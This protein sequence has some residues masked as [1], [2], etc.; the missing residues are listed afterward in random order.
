MKTIN[1]DDRRLLDILRSEDHGDE[2]HE[3]MQHVEQCSHCQRRLE[4]LAAEPEVWMKAGEAL[5]SRSADRESDLPAGVRAEFQLTT[6]PDG[7]SSWTE[8]IARR[9]L[10]P[11]SHPEMLGRLGRYEVERM[12]GAGGMGIVFKAFD[13]ELNRPVAIKVLSPILAGC[14]SARMRF[15]RE[16]RA[17]AAIVHEHV[18]PIHNVETD[19]DAPF[20]VMQYI[21][22]ESLQSRIDRAGPLQICEVLRIGFQ[23]AAGL[24]AAHQQGLVHRDIK[25][26]NILLEQGVDRALLS[27]F[28]LARTADDATLT[29][30]GFHPGTPQFMSPE[31][32]AGV[33][34]DSRSD[35]FSLGG[36]LYTMC[37]S[38]PPFRSE[39]SLGVMKRIADEE[40]NRIR[41]IN[42]TIPDWLC[43]IIAKLMAKRPAD[44][45]ESAAEV[46]HLLEQCLAHVQQPDYNPLPREARLLMAKAPYSTAQRLRRGGNWGRLLTISCVVIGG[47]G[48]IGALFVQNAGR[49]ERLAALQGEWQLVAS[50]REGQALPAEEL[51]DERLIIQE[52]RFSQFQTAPSGAEIRGESGRLSIVDWTSELAIDFN[53]WEGTAHGLAQ[54]SG[55]ELVLCVT[56]EGGPRPDALKTAAGDSRTLKTYQRK[57]SPTGSPVGAATVR[58]AKHQGK[59]AATGTPSRIGT[60][61]TRPLIAE[62]APVVACLGPARTMRLGEIVTQADVV[63]G[64]D[65]S[66]VRLHVWDCSKSD[67]SRV[68]LI[69]RSELGT[70]SPDGKIMLTSEGET[71]DLG[72]KQ[73]QQYSGFRVAAGQ[74]IAA[75]QLSRSKQFASAIIHLRTD[76]ES[77]Q[78][79]PPT[80]DIRHFWNLR[81]LQLDGASHTGK[82][83]GEFPVNAR[84]GVAF[85]N[86]ESLVVHSTDQHYIVCREL[87][88]GNIRTQFAPSL[89]V[90]GAVG[91]AIAPNGQTVAAAGYQGSLFLWD[92]PSGIL[93]VR[94]DGSGL[95]GEPHSVF[96]AEVLRFSPD[97]CY[98]ALLSG[99][100]IR[101]I[102]VQTGVTLH[103]HQDP[104][105]S[106]YV[107]AQWSN[108]AA[109]I[110]LFTSSQPVPDKHADRLPCVDEWQWMKG[111][112]LPSANPHAKPQTVKDAAS[113]EATPKTSRTEVTAEKP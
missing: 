34:V 103:E 6:W 76:V 15:A 35:L 96:R 40:P 106:R 16:A 101:V 100:R 46:A 77:L 45:F 24:A 57:G 54:L 111:A 67:L 36:V 10:A 25:P 95:S 5:S 66:V 29:R 30:S 33:S 64:L 88:S 44:R 65:P 1:C 23:V 59:L 7:T 104:R 39:S 62:S 22:G 94:L 82:K 14:G 90:H 4:E 11:P 13:S 72:S 19:R 38:R 26:G 51:F 110:S 20:L 93:R 49:A 113:A 99:N 89:G 61:I 105:R 43:A 18:V 8:A 109:T 83:L 68:L 47:V 84:P 32:V 42:P 55:D 3:Q 80:E 92:V 75:L 48:L 98:L 73:T 56:R 102:D 2:V 52:S 70:L 28:G 60:P 74:H 9:L 12:I 79:D 41:E 37:T 87:P 97:S 21:A 78:T 85:A 31:Q 81:L 71:I 53:L 17:A 50:E 86:D 107:Q 58:E 91:L 112:R 69:Q 63:A 27:D 108:D